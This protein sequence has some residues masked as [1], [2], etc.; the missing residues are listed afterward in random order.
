MQMMKA[1]LTTTAFG[2]LVPDIKKEFGD[3]RP[4]DLIGSFSTTFMED[5]L[6]NF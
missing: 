2:K 4:V 3:G 5:K 6:E 1:A